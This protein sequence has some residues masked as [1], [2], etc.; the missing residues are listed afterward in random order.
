VIVEWNGPKRD[1]DYVDLVKKGYMP[2]SGELSYFYANG[3]AA[4]E[5]KMPSEAGDYDI[6]YVMEAPKDRMV[7]TK[8]T[9]TVR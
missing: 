2:T 4:N 1:G 3:K 7:L 5:L 6:R 9:I 8:R